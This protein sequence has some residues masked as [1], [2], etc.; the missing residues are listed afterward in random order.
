VEFLSETN[1]VFFQEF[2]GCDTVYN[3]QETLDEL[4]SRLQTAWMLPVLTMK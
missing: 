4:T 1:A 3:S 2:I